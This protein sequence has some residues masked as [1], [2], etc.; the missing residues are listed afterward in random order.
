MGV[1]IKFLSPL[2]AYNVII[3]RV[4]AFS[5]S[6]IQAF[7]YMLLLYPYYWMNYENALHV[8]DN[9]HVACTLSVSI[10]ILNP[11]SMLSG[12]VNIMISK[13]S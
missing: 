3:Y 12:E 11:Y 4:K 9:V 10:N 2:I 1:V 7:Y 13:L 6:F 8:V 5:L